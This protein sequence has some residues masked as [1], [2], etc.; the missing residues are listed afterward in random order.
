MEDNFD[1]T[2]STETESPFSGFGK[3]LAQSFGIAAA[4]T[5]GMLSAMIVLPAAAEKVR[6]I[7]ENRK[8]KKAAKKASREKK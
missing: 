1:N 3:E 7:R 5:A 4:T 8:L 6:Q 2:E